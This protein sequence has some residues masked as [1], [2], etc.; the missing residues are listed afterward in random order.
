V[1]VSF[2][3]GRKRSTRR[4]QK[5]YLEQIMSENGK[6]VSDIKVVLTFSFLKSLQAS[7]LQGEDQKNYTAIVFSCCIILL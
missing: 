5:W 6:N 4:K 2:I 1:A 7:V 3:G